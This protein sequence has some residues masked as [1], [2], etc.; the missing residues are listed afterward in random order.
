MIGAALAKAGI[1]P[2][3]APGHHQDHRFII[4]SPLLGMLLGVAAHAGVSW[5]CF[6]QTPRRVD[7]W[8]RRLQLVSSSAP[9]SLGHGGNDAQKTMGIIWLLLIAAE[10]RRRT[11][12]PTGWS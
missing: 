5:I 3:L 9:Y 7:Q 4:V 1:A 8:F 12:C 11:T 10:S 2:L 6:R